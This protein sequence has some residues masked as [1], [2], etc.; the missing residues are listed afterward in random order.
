M[1]LTS[2]FVYF[3]GYDYEIITVFFLLHFGLL[4]A[5]AVALFL[6]AETK[7]SRIIIAIAAILVV[8]IALVYDDAPWVIVYGRFGCLMRFLPIT[9]MFSFGLCGCLGLSDLRRSS[10]EE[11]DQIGN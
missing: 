5:V 10:D 9:A 6:L 7:K 8:S 2:I 3:F 11:V 4:L 1:K